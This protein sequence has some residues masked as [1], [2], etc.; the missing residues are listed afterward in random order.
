MLLDVESLADA[1]READELGVVVLV[2]RDRER[3]VDGDRR[4]PQERQRQADA[5]PD[6]GADCTDLEARLNGPGVGEP[7]AAEVVFHDGEADLGRAG[8]EEI[9]ADGVV[10]RARSWRNPA[11]AEPADRPEPAGVVPF[12]ERR[13]LRRVTEVGVKG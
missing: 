3:E 9:P 11:E 13:A 4:L 10:R 7:P 8:D 5:G 2:L 1:Q 6:G 12:H